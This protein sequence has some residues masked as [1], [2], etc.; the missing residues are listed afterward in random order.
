MTEINDFKNIAKEIA[1]KLNYINKTWNGKNAILE[2]KNN[3]YLQWR[4]M[5][6]IG[7]YFQ[8]LCEKKL[9]DIMTIPGNKYG[10]VQFDAFKTIQWDFKCHIQN[11]V[12]GNLK[13]DLIINDIDAINNAINQYGA[14]GLVIGLGN[15]EYNDK[16]RTFQRWVEELKGGKSDYEKERI[17]RGAFSRLRKV[18]FELNDIL[19]VKINKENLKN[20]GMYKQGRNS[21]GTQRNPKY[22][23][24]L[25][26]LNAFEYY[27]SSKLC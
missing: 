15:A 18:S 17:E 26:Y 10:N 13:T 25:R 27:F 9:H 11:D 14:I 2:M 8:F 23:L 19:L 5:E 22:E 1:C 7:F 3:N 4:Q 12:N 6:W 24:D 20:L 16:D 21:N